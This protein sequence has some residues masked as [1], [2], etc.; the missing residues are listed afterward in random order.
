MSAHMGSKSHIDTKEEREREHREIALLAEYERL[1]SGV[2]IEKGEEPQYFDEMR[3]VFLDSIEESSVG[4]FLKLSSILETG[5]VSKRYEHDEKELSENK[6]NAEKNLTQKEQYSEFLDSYFITLERDYKPEKNPKIAQEIYAKA[7]AAKVEISK[8]LQEK[9]N[10]ISE[11][12]PKSE[13]LDIL[14]ELKKEMD[15]KITLTRKST[16][17]IIRKYT[18]VSQRFHVIKKT[19]DPKKI[20]Q[21]KKDFDKLIKELEKKEK[22]GKITRSE[23][24]LLQKHRIEHCKDQDE[25]LAF[26]KMID[27]SQTQFAPASFFEV[28]RDRVTDGNIGTLMQ[29]SATGF[30]PATLLLADATF[31]RPILEHLP[32][33]GVN[34]LDD[35]INKMRKELE[36]N[37]PMAIDKVATIISEYPGLESLFKV[38]ILNKKAAKDANE[39]AAEEPDN[40][41]AKTAKNTAAAAYEAARQAHESIQKIMFLFPLKSH[42]RSAIGEL[43]DLSDPETPIPEKEQEKEAIREALE[44]VSEY[45]RGQLPKPEQYTE[46]VFIRSMDEMIANLYKALDRWENE[47]DKIKKRHPKNYENNPH[48]IALQ[49]QSISLNSLIDE[50]RFI[51]RPEKYLETARAREAR[52]YM[53]ENFGN[54]I[55]DAHQIMSQ[56]M[57][58]INSI[59]KNKILDNTSD[60]IVT[61]ALDFLQRLFAKIFPKLAAPKSDA[62][63][64]PLIASAPATIKMLQ[65][66]HERIKAHGQQ[67]TMPK[68]L[69]GDKVARS[70]A[71]T[72]RVATTT[73]PNI[74]PAHEKAAAVTH[75]YGKRHGKERPKI[76]HV[77][78]VEPQAPEP[79]IETEKATPGKKKP[80]G[81]NS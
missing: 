12:T 67:V 9:L 43:L 27:L 72:D 21:A 31:K 77:T 39:K 20:K 73:P 61:A 1:S 3:S 51:I 58:L 65:T 69:A 25:A 2:V 26:R 44:S 50:L 4:R 81:T 14:R 52:L 19:I 48:W 42:A 76:T 13:I 74:S 6:E 40:I 68:A 32:K 47:A 71:A 33:T 24:Y 38:A 66:A 56:Y 29:A 22:N 35:L 5:R 36:K 62:H 34:S 23:M 80:K 37:N 53:K 17:K 46:Q 75:H 55:K 78:F 63:F 49:R 59:K 30:M 45:L 41:K 70:S 11:T 60:N 16:I 7:K 79:F 10:S 64:V 15:N 8:G 54:K 28:T 18:T 57:P